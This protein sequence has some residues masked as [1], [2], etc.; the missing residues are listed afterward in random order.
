MPDMCYFKKHLGLLEQNNSHICK[1]ACYMLYKDQ[2]ENR[3]DFSTYNS[4]QLRKA[5]TDELNLLKLAIHNV[6]V[7]FRKQYK[8]EAE[9]DNFLQENFVYQQFVAWYDHFNLLRHFNY[10]TTPGERVAHKIL[11]EKD[12]EM[13]DY[14]FNLFEQPTTISVSVRALMY[15][16][17]T[18]PNLIPSMFNAYD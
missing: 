11:I 1:G 6:R 4:L 14:F 13:R 16:A 5:I 17:T 10:A 15:E 7:H 2:F 18:Y 8:T 12:E 9:L 3:A